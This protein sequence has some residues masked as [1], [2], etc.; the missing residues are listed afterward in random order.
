MAT[1]NRADYTRLYHLAC[2]LHASSRNSEV[3]EHSAQIMDMVEMVLGQLYRPRGMRAREL[4]QTATVP[5][6][7]DPPGVSK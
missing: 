2:L 4:C 6:P 5:G 1:F 3:R 7:L